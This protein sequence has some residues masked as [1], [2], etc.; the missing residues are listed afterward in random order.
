MPLRYAIVLSTAVAALGLAA[1]SSSQA[2]LLKALADSVNSATGGMTGRLV[3]SD[4][5]IVDTATGVCTTIN[6]FPGGAMGLKQ[7]RS[8][9]PAPRF[10]V[11]Y[12]RCWY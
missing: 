2:E 8:A 12:G 3:N 7:L 5:A 1:V 9:Y 10:T 11:N 4:Y 6:Q